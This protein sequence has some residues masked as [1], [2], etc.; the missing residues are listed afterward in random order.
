MRG[1]L[2]KAANLVDVVSSVTALYLSVWMYEIGNWVSLTISGARA[3]ILMVGIL[4]RGVVGLPA[5]G[6]DFGCVKL[7]QIIICVEAAFVALMLVRRGNL[8]FTRVTIVSI[9]GI[10]ITSAYWEMLSLTAFV[11]IL[12]HESIYIGLSLVTSVVLLTAVGRL[13]SRASKNRP[14]RFPRLLN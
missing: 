2:L 13:G 8:P 4:P 6:T 14:G 12:L 10:Y 3:T 1:D 7:I 5:G 11:P 9:V